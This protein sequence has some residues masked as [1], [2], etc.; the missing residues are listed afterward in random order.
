MLMELDITAKD[1][2]ALKSLS[3]D[4]RDMLRMKKV[5]D[6]VDNPEYRRVFDASCFKV[7]EGNYL[8]EMLNWIEDFSNR[9]ADAE[10]EQS[11]EELNLETK[12]LIDAGWIRPRGLLYDNHKDI[13]LYL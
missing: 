3:V 4:L 7:T 10:G 2:H 1:K 6:R 8:D 13:L 12:K 11:K 5:D 9:I